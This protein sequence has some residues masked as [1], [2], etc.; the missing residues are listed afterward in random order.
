L[1]DISTLK[2]RRPGRRRRRPETRMRRRPT[3]RRSSLLDISFV[4]VF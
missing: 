1:L 2:E 4:E 3:R